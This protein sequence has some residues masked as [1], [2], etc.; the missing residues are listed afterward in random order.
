MLLYLKKMGADFHRSDK[1]AAGSDLE[2]YR[3]RLEFIDRAGRRISG[4]V[5][6]NGSSR[7]AGSIAP[8]FDRADHK[9]T[10]LYN[11][12]ELG[13]LYAVARTTPY[14]KSGVLQLINRFSAVEYAAVEI[15]DRLPDAAKDY[16]E[17]VLQ[18]NR[19]YE[20]RDRLSLR[21]ELHAAI[22]EDPL[23]WARL[24][25]REINRL[26]REEFKALTLE[27]AAGAIEHFKAAGYWDD[28]EPLARWRMIRVYFGNFFDNG[29]STDLY[30][31]ACTI[32]PLHDVHFMAQLAAID[33]A[34]AYPAKEY[35]PQEFAQ[36][37]GF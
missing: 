19:D 25:R 28:P 5:S 11:G 23:N 22:R 14:T 34:F 29:Y 1:T 16:P 24:E 10:W 8:D 4:D 17:E 13:D 35:T 18:L 6:L 26:T 20:E 33:P 32:N 21:D 7:Y 9:G 30:A 31:D 2:N 37:L 3:L 15:V 36:M 12:C 27:A